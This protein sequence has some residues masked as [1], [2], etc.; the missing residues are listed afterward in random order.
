MRSVELVVPEPGA[1][2]AG[3]L[4]GVEGEVGPADEFVGVEGRGG[5]GGGDADTDGESLGGRESGRG[6]VAEVFSEAFGHGEGAPGVAMGA[7]DDEFLAAVAGGE[8]GGADVAAEDACG[9][10]EDVVAGRM[11]VAIVDSFEVVEIGD[12]DREWGT[13][14]GAGVGGFEEAVLQ[15]VSVAELGEGV[16][17]GASFEK[18]VVEL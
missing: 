16:E 5:D 2:S 10:S 18:V 9:P 11:A 3:L 1:I 4:G 17:G 8:I 15:L 12:P 14:D 6:P 13:G 7:D